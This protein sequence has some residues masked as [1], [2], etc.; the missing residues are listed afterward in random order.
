MEEEK[1]KRDILNDL[2]IFQYIDDEKYESKATFYTYHH[3]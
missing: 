3:N 2:T 1:T